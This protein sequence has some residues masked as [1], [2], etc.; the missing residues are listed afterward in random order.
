MTLLHRSRLSFSDLVIN[1]ANDSH[2]A[3]IVSSVE[4]TTCSLTFL[5]ALV[6]AW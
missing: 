2:G 4:R 6:Y 1:R 5:P 3:S